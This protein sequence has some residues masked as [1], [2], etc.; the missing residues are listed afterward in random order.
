[1]HSLVAQD[2][3]R[4][5][6]NPE[7]IKSERRSKS[8]S[9]EAHDIPSSC[10]VVAFDKK[11]RTP[12]PYCF[13]LGLECASR[14]LCEPSLGVFL[15]QQNRL[16]W[17]ASACSAVTAA[18]NFVSLGEPLPAVPM[19]GLLFNFNLTICLIISFPC[20]LN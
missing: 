9:V 15:E 16:T 11:L 6:N 14:V 4:G 18:V 8:L 2:D 19:K 10:K 20:Q 3:I 5:N 13:E 7:K 17:L 12:Q 1:M